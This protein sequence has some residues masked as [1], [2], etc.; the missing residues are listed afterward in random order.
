MLN[1][2][3]MGAVNGSGKPPIWQPPAGQKAAAS[4]MAANKE[5]GSFL[6]WVCGN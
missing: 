2:S 3:R 5:M 4:G 6:P 1:R